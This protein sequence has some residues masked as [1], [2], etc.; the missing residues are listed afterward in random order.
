MNW[1]APTE[2]INRCAVLELRLWSVVRKSFNTTTDVLIFLKC[3]TE[4]FEKHRA[5][6]LTEPANCEGADTFL[7]VYVDVRKMGF[8]ATTHE[9]P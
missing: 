8:E 7:E 4:A 6:L 5:K 2:K 3:V 1:V 9:N